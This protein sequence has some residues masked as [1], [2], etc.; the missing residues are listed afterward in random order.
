MRQLRRRQLNRVEAFYRRGLSALNQNDLRQVLHDL[1]RDLDERADY[2]HRAAESERTVPPYNKQFSGRLDELV[3]LRERLKDD[4]AG[5][6]SGVHGL[7]GV[8][9]T[10]LAFTYAHAFAGV[11]PGGRFLLPCEGKTSLRDA[12][13][14]L[15]DLFCERIHEQERTTPNAYFAAIMRCLRERLDQR[16]H[17]LLVLDNVTDPRMLLRQETDQVT[18]LGSRSVST[19]LR[20]PF[21]KFSEAPQRS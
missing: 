20:Q 14:V 17:I 12:A 1:A 8:G 7:G 16:G 18:A 21:T 5:V 13:L 2:V 6:I 15:G 4:C 11:Y 9:K 3:N 10:E 19:I